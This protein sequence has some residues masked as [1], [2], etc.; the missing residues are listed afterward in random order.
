[1]I[2]CRVV[3]VSLLISSSSSK[4]GGCL[5]V[6]LKDDKYHGSNQD[7]RLLKV[8]NSNVEIVRQGGDGG[9]G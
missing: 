5:R 1:M 7:A 3:K 4:V 6:S 8:C 9:G 2:K